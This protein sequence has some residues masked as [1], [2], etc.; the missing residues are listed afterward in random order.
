MKTISANQRLKIAYVMSRF[1]KHTET[2]IVNEMC[3][4]EEEGVPIEVFPLI[5]Q[6]DRI[7]HLEAEKFVKCAHY[8]F[9]ISPSIVAAN[10]KIA[11]KDVRL[12]FKTLFEVLAGAFGSA[13]YFFGALGIFPKSV[14]F[15]NRMV[16]AGVT[17]IHAHFSNHP[18]VAAL[19]VHR[20]TG[21]PFSFTAH[22]HDI[23]VD[24]T[25]LKEKVEAAAFAVTVSEYNRKLMIDDCAIGAERKIHVIHCGVDTRKFQ[26][27]QRNS[28]QAPVKIVCVASLVEVKGHTYLIKAC[29]LLR[30]RKLNFSCDLIGEGHYREEIEQE[31]DTLGLGDHIRLHG[32]CTQD[33]VREFLNSSDVCVLASV[34]TKRGAREGIPVSLMEAMAVGLPVVASEISGIPELVENDYSGFL[35]PPRDVETLADRLGK[36]IID[37]R[38]RNRMGEAGR[39]VISRDFNLKSNVKYLIELIENSRNGA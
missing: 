3:A 4:V 11:K 15:A 38:A 19:I 26:A 13:N 33:K 20:L 31:I 32:A 25:M 35:V 7:I 12:Y 39:N 5:R 23:H 18:G 28:S 30:E 14:L 37:H 2:F 16:E 10:W 22:G 34:P 24:R 8:A 1:P 9:A 6:K 21:I 29:N 27:V 36:L 17:H